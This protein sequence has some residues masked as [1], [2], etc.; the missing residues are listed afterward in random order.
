LIDSIVTNV[1]LNPVRF[2]GSGT[3]SFFNLTTNFGAINFY[4]WSF[5]DGKSSS[6]QNPT[7]NYLVPGNYTTQLI[8]STINGCRDTTRFV[9]TIRVFSLPAAGI[10]GDSIHCSPGTYSYNSVI[11]S[12][13]NIQTYQWFVNGILRSNTINLTTN[14]FAGI[15]S[16][17]LK[18]TTIN[19]CIDSI[20]KLIIVDSVVAKF[21]I[22]NPKICGDSG[23]VRFTNQSASRFNNLQYVWDFGDGQT[24]T[25]T[26]PIHFYNKAGSYIVSLKANTPNGC[27]NTVITTDTVRI[28][29]ITI[30]T[31]I[32]ESEKC[33]QNTLVY[34]AAIVTEDKV[35]NYNWRL[36][37]TLVSTVDT[38]LFNFTNAATYTVTLNL[39]T[40]FGCDITVAKSVIIHP[41]PVPA[42]APDTTICLGG[43]VLLRSYDGVRF[44]WTAAPGLQ[45]INTATPTA[46][47]AASTKYFV[48]VTNQFGCIQKDTVSIQVDIPVGLTV[49][50]TDSICIGERTQLRATSS[51][52]NYLWSPA[53]GLS[54]TTIASPFAAPTITTV[55]R[56]IAFSNNVCKT[57]TGFVVVAVGNIPTVNAGA[58]R[59]IAAGTSIQLQA[60]TTG[61]DINAY[62]WTPATGLSCVNCANPSFVADNDI[63]YKVTIRTIYGCTATDE[64]RIVVFCG[65][66]QLYIP[67][68]F[69]P[70]NDGLNDRFYIKGYGI[71]K[72]KK[73]L[74]F[75][76][77]GQKVFE[78]QNV[79]VND[80]SQ[81]W[82]GT[83][84][85]QPAAQT[86]AY[87]Y[88]LEVICKDGQEFNYKGT[89][90]LVK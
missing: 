4:S 82:D 29:K 49:S 70:N 30:A 86:A 60:Q 14:F 16:V 15:Q 72:I 18:V 11:N 46:T 36:N 17:S 12:V 34:K 13:D 28:Y 25:A 38:M 26:N 64:V 24:G 35:I 39:R 31:I 2:C 62:L 37:G 45:N 79:P 40:Q 74:I 27:S 88:V 68:A 65:K 85:G 69:S 51:V 41:L 6:L 55:Y 67:N 71:A 22:V 57:D 83:T 21:T 50:K 3:A 87:V 59:N 19:G 78:K 58:D 53:V 1:G 10:R 66:G 44:E 32:G 20:A 5:G 54:S 9:D 89:V 47:P 23:T 80:A 63:T 48:K 7:N 56:V 42:A 75:N 43:T 76:R 8:A 73:M 52:S 77:Y 90:M 61:A 84:K 33:M 81:G